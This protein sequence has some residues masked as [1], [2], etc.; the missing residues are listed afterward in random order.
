MGHHLNI[1]QPGCLAL[2]NVFDVM[3][4]MSPSS[5][6]TEPSI[7]HRHRL[8][9]DMLVTV[10]MFSGADL[11]VTCF[12]KQKASVSLSRCATRVLAHDPSRAVVALL[13]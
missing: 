13:P 4:A 12:R 8:T 2:A 9:D 3:A 6:L 5:C 10:G 1:Q 7:C 11:S